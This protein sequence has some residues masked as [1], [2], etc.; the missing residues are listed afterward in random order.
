MFVASVLAAGCSYD[1]N[2]LRGRRDASSEVL[3]G[4][5]R[6]DVTTEDV[7]DVTTAMDTP[8]VPDAIDVLDITDSRDSENLTVCTSRPAPNAVDVGT[9]I[10]SS[11]VISSDTTGAPSLL[12]PPTF[13]SD[14]S[15]N[16]SMFPSPER[17]YR[18]VVEQG[19][20]LY[21][22]TD[23]PPCAGVFDTIVYIQ[24][25]CESQRGT[26]LAC[27]D[28][29]RVLTN[30]DCTAD[31]CPSLASSAV[32]DGLMPGQVVYIVVDGYQGRAGRFRLTLT[33]NAAIN[34]PFPAPGGSYMLADR[35]GCPGSLDTTV[36]T[37][38][39]PTA[40]DMVTST[41]SPLLSQPGDRLTGMRTLPLSRIAGVA[42]ETRLARNALMLDTRCMNTQATID[43]LINNT[44]VH[45]FV[46]TAR[47]PTTVPLRVAY[48]T[49]APLM[50][51]T[52]MAVPV[53][54]RLREIVPP[55]CG[56][57]EF[58]RTS[59]GGTLTLLG[60]P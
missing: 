54:L 19:P 6:T 14:C 46:V 37:V 59:P 39:F 35:C 56:G 24:T 3:D 44:V 48:Q 15:G 1:L 41:T 60:S 51:P 38:P 18:Y 55:N 12:T 45:S 5:S 40:G 33:E 36:R 42:L 17:V 53:S 34:A 4:D 8:E 27:D 10:G 13:G 58:E 29:D 7:T 31:A 49:I 57:V 43:L 47:T 32:A 28:D 25:S 9:R 50:V 20:Q 30:C 22:T 23:A 16:Y 11:L 26:V 2:R 21:A 52:T